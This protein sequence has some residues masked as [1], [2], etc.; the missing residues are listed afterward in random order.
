M[1]LFNGSKYL[2]LLPDSIKGVGPLLGGKTIFLFSDSGLV[3]D[4]MGVWTAGMI[5]GVPPPYLLV[6]LVVKWDMFKPFR[7]V[8]P[9]LSDYIALLFESR[10]VR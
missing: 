7:G 10:G 9:S 3:T 5:E 8:S 4:C 6:I 2:G 1:V